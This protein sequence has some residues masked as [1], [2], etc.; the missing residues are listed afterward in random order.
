MRLEQFSRPWGSCRGSSTA[1]RSP[2]RFLAMPWEGER[3]FTPAQTPGGGGHGAG[4]QGAAALKTSWSSPSSAAR[5][6]GTSIRALLHIAWRQ[7]PP[8]LHLE[9]VLPLISP[10]IRRDL[11]PRPRSCQLKQQLRADDEA[12]E[13]PAPPNTA[14]GSNHAAFVRDTL[15]RWKKLAVPSPPKTATQPA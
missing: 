2:L 11:H 15:S 13:L 9:S 6:D 5:V 3:G 1:A 4:H 14:P 12:E 8:I 10:K 7:F